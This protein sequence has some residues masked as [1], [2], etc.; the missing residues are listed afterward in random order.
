MPP[1]QA[2][3]SGEWSGGGNLGKWTM[4][5]TS[6]AQAWKDEFDVEL[7]LSSQRCAASSI[8]SA[9][10]RDSEIYQTEDK[11]TIVSGSNVRRFFEPQGLT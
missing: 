3:F 9:F 5:L 2:D 7:D 8:F 6:K 11:V 10:G 4:D 1:S